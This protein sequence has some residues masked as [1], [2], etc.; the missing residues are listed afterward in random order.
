KTLAME[1]VDHAKA[2]ARG[3]VA[4]GRTDAALRGPDAAVPLAHL[5]LRVQLA[6]P[7]KDDV[8]RLGDPKVLRGDIDVQ[9]EQ[10]VDLTDQP[11]RVQ[12]HAVADHAD[13]AGTQNARGNQVQD[14]LLR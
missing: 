10:A 6:V 2:D 11:D 5:A 14:V 9:L 1:Q 7:R 3:L 13:L 4:V 12:H 8:R